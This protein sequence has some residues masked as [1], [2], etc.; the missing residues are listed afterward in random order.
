V[1]EAAMGEYV[2]G[3]VRQGIHTEFL[4]GNLCET[5]H[6]SEKEIWGYI[7]IDCREVGK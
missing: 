4:R 5:G 2:T 1:K 3:W 7:K 6:F